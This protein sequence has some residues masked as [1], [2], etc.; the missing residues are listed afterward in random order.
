MNIIPLWAQ[1]L[2]NFFI[3]V[4][5]IVAGYFAVYIR[6]WYLRP[7]LEVLPGRPLFSEVMTAHV[8][9]VRNKG[10]TAAKKLYG[11]LVLDAKQ[12]DILSEAGDIILNKN[13]FR[14]IRGEKLLLGGYR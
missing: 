9:V 6:E 7:K 2:I 3:F 1:F 14:E 11:A 8:I 5:G 4:L 10:R 13:N 12:E